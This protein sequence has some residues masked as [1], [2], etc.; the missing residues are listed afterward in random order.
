MT[1]R[2][3]FN[4]LME[5]CDKGFDEAT[6]LVCDRHGNP[7]DGFCVTSALRIEEKDGENTVVLQTN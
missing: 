7:F 1:V 3:L 4:Y 5:C 2:E 6:V